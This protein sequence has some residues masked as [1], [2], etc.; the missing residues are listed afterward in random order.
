MATQQH[1]QHMSMGDEDRLHLADMSNRRDVALTF[2]YRAKNNKLDV[3]APDGTV[4]FPDLYHENETR[5]PMV[6]VTRDRFS[7]QELAAVKAQSNIEQSRLTAPVESA[8]KTPD[9][10]AMPVT[11]QQELQRRMSEIHPV[12]VL[13]ASAASRFAS[14]ERGAGFGG[15]GF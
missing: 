11:D 12:P 13:E 4:T 15:S 6:F 10:Q 14:V 2:G 5:S 8:V 9:S 3:F 1:A 7:K